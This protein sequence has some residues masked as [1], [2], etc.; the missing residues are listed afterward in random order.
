[1]LESLKVNDFDFAYGY[2]LLKAYFFAIRTKVETSEYPNVEYAEMWRAFLSRRDLRSTIDRAIELISNPPTTDCLNF[3]DC[4][5][6]SAYFALIHRNHP[7]ITL[8]FL[9][10]ADLWDIWLREGLFKFAREKIAEIL[11]LSN[12]DR[13]ADLGCGSVSPVY[14]GELVGPNGCYIGIDYSK[15]LISIAKSRVVENKLDWVV[16]RCGDVNLKLEFD[17]KF[18][19]VVCS[20]ILQY[21]D[22]K[23]VLNNAIRA[24]R[25]NGT[26]VVFSE[27][28]SDLEPEKAELF[29]L[30][31]TLI[32]Q[33]RGFP[34]VSEILEHLEK[35]C[36]FRYKMIGKNFL[37]IDVKDSFGL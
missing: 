15:P 19:Y 24:L 28:F 9:K 8:G 12:G 22:F 4:L 30:Y 3:L 36:E 34:K 27:V 35:F 1:M 32:P 20:S 37:K 25:G 17:S 29:E 5:D 23:I 2:L 13:I 31:Y 11:S 7:N 33:F 6:R 16:L 21:A 26:I 10:D 18:D 14:Y